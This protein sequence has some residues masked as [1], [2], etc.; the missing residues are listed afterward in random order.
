MLY[1]DVIEGLQHLEG[2]DNTALWKMVKAERLT[3][4]NI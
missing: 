1:N 2:D 3:D 4:V